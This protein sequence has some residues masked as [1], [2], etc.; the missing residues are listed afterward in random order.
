MRSPVRARTAPAAV[1]GL[2]AAA[3]DLLHVRAW[4][5]LA[6]L[7][8]LGVVL[9]LP[10]SAEAGDQA[11]RG[12]APAAPTS[13]PT[14]VAGPATGP[15][16]PDSA[17]PWRRDGTRAITPSGQTEWIDQLT[18]ARRRVLDLGA[19]SQAANEV[20]AQALYSDMPEGLELDRI[21]A[22]RTAARRKYVD[23]MEALPPLVDSARAAGVSP[24][25]L[26]IYEA[27]VQR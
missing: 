15:A 1:A 18:Q 7:T 4:S 23:A 2:F 12:A 9:A 8:A 14:T 3:R 25:V 16:A 21:K 26:K 22:R 6:R 24:D 11:A 13:A 17:I 5:A 10:P 19:A 27:S 20:Y